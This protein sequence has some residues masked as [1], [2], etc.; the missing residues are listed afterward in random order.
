MWQAIL[1]PVGNI[2]TTFLKNKA[3][4]KQAIHESKLR[5]IS[6]DSNWEEQQAAASQSSWKDEWFAIIL[7]L[8]LIGA[9]IPSMVPYVQEGFIVLSSMP[10]YY[11]GFLAAAIAASFGIKS[12]S[13]WGKK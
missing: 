2:V 11:K 6:A 12:V 9:F 4:E 8:P 7:S 3:A 5:Q 10:D 1:G 13:A